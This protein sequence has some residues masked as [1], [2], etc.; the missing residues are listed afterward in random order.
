M[1]KD[2][3]KRYAIVTACFMI[4]AVGVGT[5]VSYGVFFSVLIEEFQW[6]RAAISGASSLALFL[7]GFLAIFVGRL[8]DTYGP[9]KLLGIASIFFGVGVML[10]SQVHEL[11]QLYLFYGIIFGIGL[12]A[13][14][15]IALT[16]TARWFSQS[17]G[18]MTGIVKVGTGAGQFLVPFVAS[19]LITAY[20]W[21][22][23]NVILG[24]FA[25]FAL[26]FLSQILQRD[27]RDSIESQTTGEQLK[28]PSGVRSDLKRSSLGAREAMRTRQMWIICGVNMLLVFSLMII[29]VHIVP[30][31]GDIGLST[32]Q[33]AGALS[34]IGAVSMLG[35]FVCGVTIDKTGSKFVMVACFFILI[36]SLLWLQVA[37]SLGALYL[38]AAVYG[39]AHGG[40]FTAI[41]PLVAE[42]F[43]TEAHGAIFGIVVFSGTTGGA[44]GPIVAGFLFDNLGS[45]NEVFWII[46]IL[47]CIGLGLILLLRPINLKAKSIESSRSY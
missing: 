31:A 27:P 13:V 44:V 9:R 16:T 25:L 47:S 2:Q 21:R 14:D 17:R 30:H 15:V 18:I 36:L 26:F 7:S 8:N 23:T 29:L 5:L 35:R 24:S 11:W 43:G 37:D 42:V 28:T 19:L 32:L 40:F 6:S 34:T 10:V 3:K 46:K 4:Q 45:Y 12:S 20:G 33:A 39:V 22:M 41:S 38:F 1:Q